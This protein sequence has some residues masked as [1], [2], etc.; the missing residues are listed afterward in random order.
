V[1]TASIAHR[2]ADPTV[3]GSARVVTRSVKTELP[4][5]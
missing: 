4:N 2:R 5:N 3:V 1:L